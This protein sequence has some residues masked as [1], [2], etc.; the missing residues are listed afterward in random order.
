MPREQREKFLI[1][2]YEQMWGNINRHITLSWQP[3]TL[4]VFVAAALKVGLDGQLALG[5]AASV[6]LVVTAWF[7]GHIYDSN[8]W[9]HRNHVIV[10]NLE[11][12]FQEPGDV[13]AINPFM[14]ALIPPSRMCKLLTTF[15]VQRFLAFGL[16]CFLLALVLVLETIPDVR[17]E[18]VPTFGSYSHWSFGL[19]PYAVGIASGFWV[20]HIRND[21]L[22]Q[23][24]RVYCQALA[25]RVALGDKVEPDDQAFCDAYAREEEAK[26]ARRK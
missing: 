5:I 16:A 8:E 23:Y 24:K 4:I 3:A 22:N 20:R 25:G 10:A 14:G 26:K 18:K 7:L 1:G 17:G 12:Y 6:G 15:K 21:R 2:M 11:R 19:V 9:Y 13:Q